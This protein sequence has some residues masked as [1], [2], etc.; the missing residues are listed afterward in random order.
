MSIADA[1]AYLGRVRGNGKWAARLSLWDGKFRS[2]LLDLLIASLAV[3]MPDDPAIWQQWALIP[4]NI[5]LF[6]AMLLRRRFPLVAVVAAS[7]HSLLA[8]VDG[9]ATGMVVAMYTMASRRGPVLATWGAA[10]IISAAHVLRVGLPENY[11]LWSNGLLTL[12]AGVGLGIVLLAGMP[13]LLGL[14]LYSRKDLL[15]SLRERAVQAERERDLLAER[16]VTAE[17]RRIAREMHDVVAH[18]VS[19]ISL[20]AGALTMTATDQRTEEVAEI[21]RESSS[22]ALTELREMLRALRDD[23]ENPG[24]DHAAP[25]LDGVRELVADSVAAGANITLDMPAELPAAPMA[26]GRAAYR[27]MQEALTNAGKHAPGSPVRASVL[28]DDGLVVEVTNQRGTGTTNVEGSGYGLIGMRERVTLAG[29]TLQVG[30]TEDD[31]YRV[32]AAFPVLETAN[33]S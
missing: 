29:G 14:W 33:A 30:R 7:V 3:A 25:A 22:T 15:R 5:V 18:R 21:I 27:V 6:G 13:L 28:A 26:V 11:S 23:A 12:V 4:T 24:G 17:R 19:V 9:S 10:G 16:A 20:Q 32:R 31:G 8:G 2:L 1:T